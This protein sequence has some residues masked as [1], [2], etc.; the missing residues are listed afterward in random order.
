MVKDMKTYLTPTAA[1][2]AVALAGPVLADSQLAA[3]AGLTSAEAAGLSLTE[4][5]QAKFNRDNSDERQ[6]LQSGSPASQSGRAA[7]A[8]GAGIPADQAR[9][10]SLTEI[11]AVKFSRGASDNDQVRPAGLEAT[12]STRSVDARGWE[13]LVSN[14][15]L[16]PE[17]AANLSLTEI[18]AQKFDRDNQ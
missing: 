2:L 6:N 16:T 14:A 15:G 1:V 3:N 8:A 9:D 17:E 12:L 18:A 10:L 11:A 5:A 13:Q 4:I 7:L